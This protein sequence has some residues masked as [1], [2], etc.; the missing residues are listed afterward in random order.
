MKQK[1]TCP[2][3]KQLFEV[4]GEDF[5]TTVSC[6]ACAKK[7][8]PMKEY[9]DAAW[10]STKTPEFRAALKDSIN[11]NNRNISHAD[12]VAGMQNK[13]MGFKCLLGEPSQLISGMRKT[14]FNV[15]VVLYM[16]AP[17]IIVPLWAHHENNWWLLIG[18]IISWASSVATS[19]SVR[20]VIKRKSVGGSLLLACIVLWV[21]KG[22]HYYFTFYALCALWGC[23][24]FQMAE[25]AQWDYAM[26]SLIENPELFNEAI[27]QSKI[28]IVR[29]EID[30]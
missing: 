9:I 14:I 19:S 20:V 18:I 21:L 30:G 17:L 8:N 22:I 23:M 3:C 6:P 12:F 1:T 24:L 4:P 10:E 26:Q 25:E 29:N 11:E 13:T 5:N 7:F 2:Q 15:L 16:I 28:M 27:V